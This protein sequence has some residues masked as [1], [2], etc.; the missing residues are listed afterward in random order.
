MN[1][2]NWGATPCDRVRPVL[3]DYADNVLSAPS[4]WEVE[5]HIAG[6]ADCSRMALEL[7]QTVQLLRDAPRFDT[8]DGFMAALHARLD[9]VD[10]TLPTADYLWSRAAA[11]LNAGTRNRLPVWS[12]GLATAG[13]VCVIALN[14]PADPVAAPVAASS[15]DSLHIT[16]ASSANS[17]F[18]DPAADNL[19]YRA[20]QRSSNPAVPF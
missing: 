13:V 3:S 12:L 18:S 17:P 10:P 16:V 1:F 7:R 14:R 8:G 15:T 6:C 20:S 2:K 9:T 19:E 4:A 11:W 5:K